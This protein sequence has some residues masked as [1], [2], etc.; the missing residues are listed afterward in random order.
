MALFDF[1]SDKH[2]VASSDKTILKVYALTN[3]T[4][5]PSHI[6]KTHWRE[7]A[8]IAPAPDRDGGDAAHEDE[9]EEEEEEKSYRG[10]MFFDGHGK[11]EGQEALTK[12]AQ[13]LTRLQLRV[14]PQGHSFQDAVELGE[15]KDFGIHYLRL[16]DLFNWP[17]HGVD[18]AG[19]SV[20]QRLMLKYTVPKRE[21]RA[22]ASGGVSKE[23]YEDLKKT[24]NK[25]DE[26]LRKLRAEVEEQEKE[27][28]R[29]NDERDDATEQQET[30][31]RELEK[32]KDEE[33]G[34][35]MKRKDD[36][37]RMLKKRKDREIQ[38]L[39]DDSAQHAEELRKLEQ[40]KDEELRVMMKRKDDELQIV[41]KRNDEES[42]QKNDELKTLKREKEEGAKL[43]KEKDE[44][45]K[46]LRE[47]VVNLR[48]E[49]KAAASATAAVKGKILV[50]SDEWHK[51]KNDNEALRKS[52]NE[53]DVEPGRLRKEKEEL[54]MANAAET[55]KLRDQ[56]AQLQEQEQRR[57]QPWAWTIRFL[58]EYVLRTRRPVPQDTW[59]SVKIET[60]PDCHYAYD[61]STNESVSPFPMA[62]WLVVDEEHNDWPLPPKIG[63]R[64]VPDQFDKDNWWFVKAAHPD[65][66]LAMMA[67]YDGGRSSYTTPNYRFPVRLPFPRNCKFYTT[68]QFFL[69]G[70]NGAN[71]LAFSYRD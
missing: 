42:K 20:W 32:E 50:N 49:N 11:I 65:G 40:K 17:D 71:K 45:V 55:R 35:L 13:H 15:H 14:S 31:L 29:L 56:V 26:E 28:Q 7:V 64:C 59:R 37:L 34:E 4:I 23:K 63:V 62:N 27:I 46:T 24:V 52:M 18:M 70:L 19:V 1:K 44:E 43:S 6:R 61:P 53:K 16:N 60:P 12:L 25:K 51:L 54:V 33:I 36:E 21:K 39:K 58:G 67:Y 2:F 10:L 8:T 47:E 48:K 41:Q 3:P 9:E 66:R 68:T 69:I 30:E 22:A 5:H 57:N 38:T